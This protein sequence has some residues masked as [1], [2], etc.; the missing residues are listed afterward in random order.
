MNDFQIVALS[1]GIA[2]AAF[3]IVGQLF[4]DR[5]THDVDK[6][7]TTS[8]RELMRA[9]V[10]SVMAARQKYDD[11]RERYQYAFK[12]IEEKLDLDDG[13]IDEAIELTIDL[14]KQGV[15]VLGLFGLVDVSAPHP[16]PVVEPLPGDWPPR[17]MR[18]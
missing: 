10:P 13:S 6:D 3:L 16:H 9:A 12:R 18:G 4:K 17:E 8:W 1:V 7:G 5:D 2:V 15:D 14:I 11:N